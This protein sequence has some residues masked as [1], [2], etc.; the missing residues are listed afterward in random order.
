[1]EKSGNKDGYAGLASRNGRLIDAERLLRE[2]RSSLEKTNGE[3]NIVAFR[4]D[5]EKFRQYLK[6]Q[7][8]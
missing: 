4:S 3:K 8:G 5:P 7:E 1:M 6:E 2:A